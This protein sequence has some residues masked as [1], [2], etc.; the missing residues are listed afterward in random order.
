MSGP[1][2]IR[3]AALLAL[4]FGLWVLASGPIHLG[5]GGNAMTVRLSAVPAVS[6]LIGLLSL[7][8]ATGLWTRMAW[9]WWLALVAALFQG[10]RIAS[11][12]L[13]HR[14]LEKMPGTTTLAL[15]VLL[16]VF[17]VLLFMPKARATCNR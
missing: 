5:A 1:T 16:V 3:F 8:L 12:H 14:G 6:W 2:A 17:I 15:L 7:G 10:W 9:A 13:A 11:A 4:G